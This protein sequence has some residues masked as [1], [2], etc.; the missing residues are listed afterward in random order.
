MGFW[1]RLSYAF[2][3]W[4]S[5]LVRGKIPADAAN[6]L[7]DRQAKE[8]SA[9][10]EPPPGRLKPVHKAETPPDVGDRALQMLALLQREGRLIDFLF[11]DVTPYPDAQLGAAVRSVHQSCREVLEHY[12]KLVPIIDSEEDRPVSLEAGLDPASIK[13]LGNVTG[14]QPTRGVL[15]HRG[16]RAVDINLPSLPEGGGRKVIAPAEVEIA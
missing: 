3:C 2:R 9:A 4:F 7:L 12:V 10:G 11:E 13:L 1:Q 8:T 5:I 6:Q 15:R 14:E 16:W